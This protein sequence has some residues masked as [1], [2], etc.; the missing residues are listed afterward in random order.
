MPWQPWK[1]LYIVL[2]K[3]R[4]NKIWH[5]INW[6]LELHR[7]KY[8]P[9]KTGFKSVWCLF[10]V[11]GTNCWLWWN[12]SLRERTEFVWDTCTQGMYYCIERWRDL[13]TF[14]NFKYF[15]LFWHNHIHQWTC[16]CGDNTTY[17]GLVWHNY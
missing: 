17:P 15:T 12:N 9:L 8:Q 1:Q 4:S 2:Q 13:C 10:L 3:L 11:G 16:L 7:R 14:K 6:V 5:Q